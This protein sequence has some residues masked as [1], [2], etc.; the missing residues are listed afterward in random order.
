MIKFWIFGSVNRTSLHHLLLENHKTPK[1]SSLVAPWLREP[2][3]RVREEVNWCHS[4]LVGRG[5]PSL[6]AGGSLNRLLALL[7]ILPIEG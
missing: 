3:W 4:H 7:A 6:G 1:V 5:R 2:Q